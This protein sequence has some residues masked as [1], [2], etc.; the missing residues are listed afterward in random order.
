MVIIIVILSSFSI[1]RIIIQN[2]SVN[3]INDLVK[4]YKT[5]NFP[6]YQKVYV[7]YH[8]SKFYF[9]SSNNSYLSGDIIY[10]DAT[11][12]E[13][14]GVHLFNGFDY[15]E[16]LSNN[17]IKGKLSVNNQEYIKRGF[18]LNYL[19]DVLT[20][21]IY[22]EY[23][24]SYNYLLLALTL[25]VDNYFPDSFSNVI[26]VIGISHLFVISG[27]HVDILVKIYRKL[28]SKFRINNNISNVFLV[29]LLL[30]YLII[31]SFMVSVLRVIISLFIRLLFGKFVKQVNRLDVISLNATIM[32][33][34]NPLFIASYSFL[35]SYLS[36]IGIIMFT[37]NT[38]NT[39]IKN[40]VLNK[41]INTIKVSLICVLMS[42]PVIININPKIN[43]LSIFFNVL[44]IPFVTYILLPLS[45]LVI[46]LKRLSPLYLIVVKVFQF[47]TTSSYDISFFFLK[48][49]PFPFIL[50]LIY[51]T[52][53]IILSKRIKLKARLLLI[54]FIVLLV[55]CNNNI[56]L[57]N[58]NNEVYF[59][60]LKNGD[61]TFISKSHNQANILIDVGDVDGSEVVS[62][63]NSLNI[64]RLDAI[65]ITHGDSDHIG[66]LRTI[67]NEFL[68][69]EIIIPRFDN[70]C[71]KYLQENG[72]SLSPLKV[73]SGDLVNIGDLSF[74]ILWP[75]NDTYDINN[76]SMVIS[77][78]LFGNDY[79]F[80]GDIEKKAELD[81]VKKYK[82]INCDIL[83]VAHHGS[84]TSSC[85]EFLESVNFSVAIA[86]NGYQNKFSFPSPKVVKRI[87]NTYHK[88][89]LNTRKNG[90]ICL[91]NK[92]GKELKIKTSFKTICY[93]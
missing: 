26:Q 14:S 33:V 23:D 59:L 87:T 88:K 57:V 16:Y 58:P 91:Y 67:C 68:V 50:S 60:D 92:K 54:S 12:E 38:K 81:F 4:V 65:F 39:R 86:M 40:R 72:I 66:G 47:L 18:S 74:N 85:N 1:R 48:I 28:I 36:V 80:M 93:E 42:I 25:G 30:F 9:N 13:F 15:K 24:S 10:I 2:N 49:S 46:F 31:T 43:I 29:L 70:E 27:L 75:V 51:Y 89:F 55:I 7:K 90:S 62:F 44:F 37:S 32:L 45:L 17:M 77:S 83:K 71:K 61:C 76:N 19:H 56:R 34:I 35:L 53:L 20:N 52:V 84:Q 79:L 5:E 78:N 21:Y 11:V 41:L 63:L 82:T 22:N 69:K 64:S 73:A 8:G 6:D 3:A